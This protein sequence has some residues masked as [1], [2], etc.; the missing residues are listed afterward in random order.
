MKTKG[1][2]LLILSLIMFSFVPTIVYGEGGENNETS[3][4]S[5]ESISDKS[6]TEITTMASEEAASAHEHDYKIIKFNVDSG[7]AVI[8]C[9]ICG[10]EY[11]DVFVHHLNS[12]YHQNFTLSDKPWDVV[13][14]ET[15]NGQDYAWLMREFSSDYSY[16]YDFFNS[17][18]FVYKEQFFFIYLTSLFLISTGCFCLSVRRMKK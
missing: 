2:L 8:R 3:T 7:V 4:S 15:V 17:H 18:N 14:D 13:P 9:S 10:D 1:V 6:D 16:I 11:N 5:E 12:E